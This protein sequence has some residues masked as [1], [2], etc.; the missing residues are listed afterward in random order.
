MQR[1]LHPVQPTLTYDIVP[2]AGDEAAEAGR[3]EAT[4]H[5]LEVFR[6]THKGHRAPVH[7]QVPPETQLMCHVFLAFHS[8]PASDETFARS[9]SPIPPLPCPLEL[10]PHLSFLS[11]PDPG[12]HPHPGNCPVV[13]CP[14]VSTLRRLLTFLRI[15]AAGPQSFKEHGYRM[16]LIWLHGLG[17]D[18]SPIKGLFEALV[19]IDKRDLAGTSRV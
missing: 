12:F 16:L 7:R 3:V 13:P 10:W 14:N 9:R 2:Q 18:D 1:V 8:K 15:S 5:L 4:R 19:A 17:K 6:R 11:L